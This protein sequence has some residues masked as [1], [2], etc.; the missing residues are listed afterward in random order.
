MLNYSTQLDYKQIN[1]YLHKCTFVICF[2][3]HILKPKNEDGETPPYYRL[4]EEKQYSDLQVNLFEKK[5]NKL[6][7]L[8]L[9]QF[10][11]QPAKVPVYAIILAIALFLIGSVMITLGALMLTRRIETQVCFIILLHILL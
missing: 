1:L 3:R 4:K 6:M 11:E 8:F 2:S 9:D 10:K 7:I 5:R